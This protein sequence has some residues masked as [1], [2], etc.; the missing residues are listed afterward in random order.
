MAI[1]PVD[2]RIQSMVGNNPLLAPEPADAGSENAMEP[3]Q[4]AGALSGLKGLIKTGKEV[5]GEGD[6]AK[7]ALE[8]ERA[9]DAVPEA[10]PPGTEGLPPVKPQEQP[11]TDQLTTPKPPEEP[12]QTV[13]D[14]EEKLK[15]FEDTVGDMPTEG[16]PPETMLNLGRLSGPDDFKQAA[17]ALVRSSGTQI[18]RKTQEQSIANAMAK[19]EN[20]EALNDL[21]ALRKQY[22]ELPDELVSFRIGAYKNSM[23]FFDLAKKAYTGE[24]TPEIKAQLLHLYNQQAVYNS[25]YLALRTGAAQATAAGN[26]KMTPEMIKNI[27]R[28]ADQME[29]PAIGSKEMNDLVNDPNV[30]Q[31]LRRLVDAMVQLT[32]DGAKEGLLNKASKVG[33]INDLWDRTWKNGLLSGLGTHVVNLT[34]SATFLA[35]SVATRALAGSVGTIRRGF[36]GQAEVELGEAAAQVA[37]IVHASR[38]ALRLGWVALKTGTTREMRQGQE[39]LS[40]AGQR[41]EGQYNIFDSRDYGIENEFFVKGI[42][43]WANFVTLLGGRPIMAMDEAF[44]TLAY[45]GEI[46]AQ[47][48]RAGMQAERSALDAGKTAEEAKQAHLERMGSILGDPPPEIDEAGRDFGHMITFSRKLTGAS[49]SIQQLAQD[50]LVG[51]I[52]LPFVKTPVWVGS[53]SMQHSVFAPLSKQWR[54]DYQ[55]GGAKRELAVAKMGMGSMLMLGVGSYVA[56]GR[57]TGGGPGDTNL[58]KIYLDSGWKPYSFVF[59]AEEWDQEFVSYLRGVGIDPSIGEGGQLYVPFRGIDPVAG[60]MAMIA[61]AVEYARYEDD[62]DLVGQ[63]I[64]GAAWGLYGYIGQL[65]FLQGISSIAGAFSA[66]VPNPKHAFKSAIDSVMGTGASYVVEGSPVGVFNSARAMIERGVDPNK[67]MTAESPNMPTGIKGFYEG[68]NRSIARTP[69]LS[70]SLPKQYDYLGEEQ[71][72]VDPA[73]PWFA[74]TS[75]IRI[76]YTKQ[77][78]ADKVMIQLGLPIKKPDM[79]ITAGGVNI[80]LEVDEYTHMMKTLGTIRDA[81]GNKVKDAIWSR[82]T[83]PGFEMDDLNVQQDN[84]REVY[85]SFTK[86]AQGE[87]ITE[88]KFASRIQRR[89]EEAQRKLPRLGNY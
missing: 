82:Y 83:S 35:S 43:G 23:N 86:A 4:V 30:D 66:T 29:V 52:I 13:T 71:M 73:A 6:T 10:T 21:E 17:E 31:G 58:R 1:K 26:I 5:F 7:K 42:N 27:L 40:D 11:K 87:L 89:V 3:V 62:E 88:S 15:V 24:M 44:K 37:G 25:L 63:V 60:P 12:V 64:L 61:D 85:Q 19:G 34:S 9:I 16:R 84:I 2:D 8:A 14:S 79:S 46:Y 57:I 32:D 41:F 76:S 39:L 56:D 69:F 51:R 81:A 75:G 65:P 36:G 45:R 68:L 67:R 33:L 49:A 38:D 48:H 53:E 50:H 59:Q 74:S 22:G 28:Q 18:A 72:D 20:L 80:K 55:A 78:P 54:A 77:R 47:A 70:D